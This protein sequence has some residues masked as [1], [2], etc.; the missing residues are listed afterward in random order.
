[1]EYPPPPPQGKIVALD[2]DQYKAGRTE[3]EEYVWRLH[4]YQIG[5]TTF[6]HINSL[7]D[8]GLSAVV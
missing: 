1:M 6:L 8:H 5:I 2:C 7:Y 4:S 3:R